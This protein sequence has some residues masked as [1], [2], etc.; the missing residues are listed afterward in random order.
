MQSAARM[1]SRDAY[2]SLNMGAG[3]ALFTVPEKAD[4]TV[5]VIRTSGIDAWVAG[6]VESGRKRVVIE[7]LGVEFEAEDLQL[8]DQA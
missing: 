1:S 2:G 6:K 8:R 7:P 3:F 4:A 5:R